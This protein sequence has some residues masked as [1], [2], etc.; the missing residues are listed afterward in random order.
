MSTWEDFQNQKVEIGAPSYIIILALSNL[1]R[2]ITYTVTET[3]LNMNI[4]QMLD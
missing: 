3:A 2:N 1:E 4:L